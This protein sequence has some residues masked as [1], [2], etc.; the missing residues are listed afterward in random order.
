MKGFIFY[1]INNDDERKGRPGLTWFDQWKK[2]V[3]VPHGEGLL[4]SSLSSPDANHWGLI[5]TL[6]HV[7]LSRCPCA[8]RLTR[9]REMA[10]TSCS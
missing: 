10:G 1:N 5:T 3:S 2:R 9:R 8:R 4:E 7:P 6:S